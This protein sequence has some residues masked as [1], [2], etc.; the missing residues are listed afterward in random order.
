MTLAE[1]S[2]FPWPENEA[3]ELI[4]EVPVLA[5]RP[6][7]KHQTLM[8]A[9]SRFLEDNLPEDPEYAIFPEVD[10][11]LPPARSWVVPDIAV[12]F[13]DQIGEDTRPIELA[14]LLAVEI[15]SP[16]TVSID[17]G[18]KRDAYAA[19]GTPEY[20]TVDPDTGAVAIHIGPSEGQYR[21]LTTD[22]DGY[23]ESALLGVSF[24]I[25]R[26]GKKYKLLTR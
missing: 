4:W 6:R 8:L 16:S 15:A 2:A 21:Q 10:V 3:W 14:P 7:W 26:A 17:V 12:F 19:A 22:P 13:A 20:W 1:F 9:L 5:P 11:K 25:S 24:R 18:P 23:I